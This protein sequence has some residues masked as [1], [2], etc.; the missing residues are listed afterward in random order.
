MNVQQEP[1][2]RERALQILKANRDALGRFGV[3]SLALF[4]SVARGEER[5]GSDLDFVVEFEGTATYDR[6]ADLKFFLEDILAHKVDLVVKGALRP[7]M[8]R[9]VERDA[10]VVS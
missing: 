4:G 7:R 8:L 1:I 3:K 5:P 10:V 2:T 6:Y 9:R